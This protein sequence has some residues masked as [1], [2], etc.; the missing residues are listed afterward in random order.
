MRTP[1]PVI[2]LI[3]RNSRRARR[4][5]CTRHLAAGGSS[6]SNAART[7]RKERIIQ[8]NQNGLFCAGVPHLRCWVGRSNFEIGGAS[9]DLVRKVVLHFD[10]EC[11][12]AG[13]ECRERQP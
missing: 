13:R 9:D 12:V 2:E 3:F 4:A 8:K 10:F 6:Y 5:V 1:P 7:K 11:V